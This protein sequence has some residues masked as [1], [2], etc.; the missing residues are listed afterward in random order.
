MTIIDGDVPV[1]KNKN[2]LNCKIKG[3]VYD[4]HPLLNAHVN[5]SA[6]S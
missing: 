1:S 5:R 2:N 4:M 3:D 6:A